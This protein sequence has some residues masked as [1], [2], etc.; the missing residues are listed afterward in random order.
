[1]ERVLILGAKS[2]IARALAHRFAREGFGIIM[3]SRRAAELEN[4]VKD[5]QIRYGARAETAEFDALEYDTHADFYDR[6]APKPAVVVCAVGYLGD[7]K[8]A[9]KDIGEA[10]RIM[11]TNFTGCASVL[12]AV[13]RDFEMRR[14]GCII[15]ISSVAGERGRQSNYFYGS[16]KAALTAYLSGL[17]NRLQKSDVHVITVKPGFVATRMTEGMDLPPLLTS[18]PE[19]VAEDV[20]RAYKAGKDELYTKWFWKWIMAVIRLIPEK[21]FKRLSL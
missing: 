8:L 19:E 13:A 20:F 21:I 16:S 5:L 2:D 15:G 18:R 3:A 11:E 10:R 9:E 12:N 4:D 17:R 14:K 6:L 1:M 7:Q